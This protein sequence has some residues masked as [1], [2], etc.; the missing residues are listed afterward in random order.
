MSRF[1]WHTG[2]V[3]RVDLESESLRFTEKFFFRYVAICI[4][5][6]ALEVARLTQL[7]LIF[8]GDPGVQGSGSAR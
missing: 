7:T 3:R 2:E 4:E 1:P 6:V 5:S 8:L